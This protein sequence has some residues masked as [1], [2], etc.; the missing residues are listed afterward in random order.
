MARPRTDQAPDSPKVLEKA[1]R[2]LDSFTRQSPEWSET[3][4]RAHLAMPSTTLNR[5]LRSLEH[6]GYLLRD[7]GGRYRLGIAAIRLGQRASASI[8]LPSALD[9]SIRALSRLTGELVLLAVPEFATGLARYVATADSPKRLRVTAEVGTTVPLTA[10][11]TARTLLA[12]Q[13]P[14]QI[15]VVLRRPRKRLAAG[16]V[17]NAKALRRQLA[18]IREQGWGFSWEETYDG[19]WALA[20]PLLDDGAQAFASIGVAVP[21]TRHTAEVEANIRDAVIAT[22]ARAGRKLGAQ[23]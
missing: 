1:L 15:D 7:G 3:E 17:I 21:T 12:F 11:A 16:T 22:V 23:T 5:I 9:S 19:A 20:A 18:E 6:A 2:V 4:L 8:N 13:Q 10:G 14:A